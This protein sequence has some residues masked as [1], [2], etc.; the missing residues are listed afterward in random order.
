MS[1]IHRHIQCITCRKDKRNYK[2][3]NICECCAMVYCDDCNSAVWSQMVCC[4]AR[5]CAKC[6]ELRAYNGLT[7]R[8]S[9]RTCA[10]CRKTKCK[11]CI[12]VSPSIGGGY[13]CDG[14]IQ[15]CTNCEETMSVKRFDPPSKV[16]RRCLRVESN[17]KRRKAEIAEEEEFLRSQGRTPVRRKASENDDDDDDTSDEEE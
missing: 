14:C 16:C 12:D 5:V 2:M 9:E 4:G 17:A 3:E 10:S 1:A 8:E 11:V 13:M 7:Y 6:M 15:E